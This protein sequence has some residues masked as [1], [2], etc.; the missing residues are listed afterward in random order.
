MNNDTGNTSPHNKDG[1][2]DGTDIYLE[3]ELTDDD[4]NPPPLL[5][6]PVN[7]YSDSDDEE[8]DEDDENF[9]TDGSVKS[10][11]SIG[12]EQFWMDRNCPDELVWYDEDI[13]DDPFPDDSTAASMPSLLSLREEFYD[14]LLLEQHPAEWN[15]EHTWG[16]VINTNSWWPTNGDVHPTHYG[17]EQ[18]LPPW[19]PPTD[20]VR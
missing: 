9:S 1:N 3:D 6:R 13:Q 7:D 5:S 8:D 4:D 10:V 15:Y 16:G 11:D 19:P 14:D 20:V 2:V 12:T 18:F 17:R